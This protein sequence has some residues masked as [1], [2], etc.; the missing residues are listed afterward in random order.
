MKLKKGLTNEVGP[1]LIGLLQTVREPHQIPNLSM[2][3][4]FQVLKHELV[5]F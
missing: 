3:L 2:V 5:Y 1:F 4:G